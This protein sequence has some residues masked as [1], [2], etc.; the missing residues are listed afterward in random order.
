MPGCWRA[1]GT[2]RAVHECAVWYLALGQQAITSSRF[3]NEVNALEAETKVRI[4]LQHLPCAMQAMQHGP[5]FTKMNFYGEHLAFVCLQ[6]QG[7]T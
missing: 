1:K 5:M 2:L 3:H 7:K 6:Q 4:H